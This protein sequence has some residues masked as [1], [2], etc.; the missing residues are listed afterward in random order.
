MHLLPHKL[1]GDACDSNLVPASGPE[2]NVPF[3]HAIE[4]SAIKQK[5]TRPV[6]YAID[7]RFH[8]DE[9]TGGYPSHIG[10]KW[11]TYDDKGGT[12]AKKSEP[13]GSFSKSGIP[14]PRV[15]RRLHINSP[16]TRA[17]RISSFLGVDRNFAGIIL[18]TRDDGGDFRG[19]ADLLK[20]M[21]ARHEENERKGRAAENFESR[22]VDLKGGLTKKKG[23]V[24][25]KT[26]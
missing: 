8:E 21:Y 20:R 5:K 4:K 13:G 25:Y 16:D 12:W 6:W 11:G 2:V 22:M 18:R 7:V 10:G 9:K 24:I 19:S 1:G 26:D 15:V 14:L 23:S 17:G 3:S